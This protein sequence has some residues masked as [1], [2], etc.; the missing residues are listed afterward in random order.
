MDVLSGIIIVM[1]IMFIEY[2]LLGTLYVY[3]IYVSVMGRHVQL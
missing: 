2:N 1:I 3:C